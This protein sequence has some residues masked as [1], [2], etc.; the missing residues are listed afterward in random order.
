MKVDIWSDIMCPFCYIGK[1]KFESALEKFSDKEKIEVRWHSF[2]LDPAVPNNVD[3]DIYDY[4]AQRKGQTREWAKQV[5]EHVSQ[6]A[7]EVGL[8]YNMDEAVVANS[9]DAH[10]L[11]QLAKKWG[12]DDVAEEALFKAYFTEGKNISDKDTLTA[13]GIRIGLD[14]AEIEQLFS[15]DAYAKE[16]QYDIAVAQR[17]GINGVP[18]FVL[19]NKYGVSG[20][21]SPELFQQAL[22]QAW[23]EYQKENQ[24][25]N[26]ETIEGSACS[27]D[28]IC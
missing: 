16:V 21:Q 7:K 18:F 11:I 9:F 6:T 4:L 1:R 12:K 15:S 8:T 27:I 14:D 24:V 19:N 28:G 22:Q 23:Q 13:I 20:A 2:Q 3:G 17:L 10:R 5:N 26:I 25:V